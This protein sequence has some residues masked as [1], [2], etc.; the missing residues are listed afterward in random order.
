MSLHVIAYY[1]ASPKQPWTHLILH[2][3]LGPPGEKGEQ[4]A[5]NERPSVVASL[6]HFMI[7]LCSMNNNQILLAF[8]TTLFGKQNPV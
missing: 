3:Q 2:T 6:C 8:V 5:D 7:V 4:S 1:R